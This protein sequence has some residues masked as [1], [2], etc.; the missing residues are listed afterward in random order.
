MSTQLTI[1][2]QKSC[3]SWAY[4]QLDYLENDSMDNLLRMK[5]EMGSTIFSSLNKSMVIEVIFLGRRKTHLALS[6][7]VWNDL[8]IL[9]ALIPQPTSSYNPSKSFFTRFPLSFLP[10][11]SRF[12]CDYY[13]GVASPL[14]IGFELSRS[15]IKQC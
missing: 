5:N 15:D 8:T 4:G 14:L 11:T 1:D 9:L 2:Q 3:A 6:E 7:D 10:G 12:Q 13:L